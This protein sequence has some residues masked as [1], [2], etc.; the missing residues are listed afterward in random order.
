MT[1]R[2][3][4]DTTASSNLDKDQNTWSEYETK[5]QRAMPGGGK[6]ILC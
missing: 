4:F 6:N 3:P 1:L 2:S 5:S